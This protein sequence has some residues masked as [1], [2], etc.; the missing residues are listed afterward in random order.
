MKYNICFLIQ[1]M[2][3]NMYLQI[4]VTSPSFCFSACKNHYAEVAAVIVPVPG[5]PVIATFLFNT[6]LAMF[7]F[8]FTKIVM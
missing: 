4:V 8:L 7:A 3:C 2:K 1:N 5:M 6:S